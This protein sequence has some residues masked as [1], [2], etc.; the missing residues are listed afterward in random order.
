MSKKYLLYIHH[1]NFSSEK[2]KSDLVNRLLDDYYNS[3]QGPIQPRESVIKFQEA[4]SV[5][6]PRTSKDVL[7]DI[8]Q[9]KIELVELLEVNQDPSDHTKAQ[10]NI[11]GLWNE[12]HIL[13][14]EENEKTNA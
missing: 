1:P 13:K 2:K 10:Q 14:G 6:T 4:P 12:Y 8:E 9:A 7:R 3:L 11:Q 5:Y